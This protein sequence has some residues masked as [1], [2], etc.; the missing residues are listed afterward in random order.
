MR[1]V[2]VC[3]VNPCLPN[4]SFDDEGGQCWGTDPVHLTPAGYN[5]VVDFLKTEIEKLWTRSSTEKRAADSP[6]G[7]A[8]KRTRLADT[9]AGSIQ[10][11]SGSVLRTDGIRGGASGHGNRGRGTTRGGF[12]GRPLVFSMAV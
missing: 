5:K 8:A 1:G 7:P 3:D 6:A 11:T 12:T 4:N 2:R 10:S 9:R